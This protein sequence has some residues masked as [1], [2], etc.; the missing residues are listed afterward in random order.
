VIAVQQLGS[1]HHA[2]SCRSQKAPAAKQLHLRRSLQ[3]AQGR[4][5]ITIA[6]ETLDIAV[7]EKADES[8]SSGKADKSQKQL[9]KQGSRKPGEKGA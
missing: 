3:E 2:L 8:S 6:S 4:G 7:H 9:A 5:D 1:T